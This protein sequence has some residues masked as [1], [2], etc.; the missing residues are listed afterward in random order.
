MVP[1]VKEAIA[2]QLW[3]NQ[4]AK[5]NR[6]E[7]AS[8]LEKNERYLWGSTSGALELDPDLISLKMPFD[9]ALFI[10]KMLS[11][12]RA[13]GTIAARAQRLLDRY[14]W[15]GPKSGT[16]AQWTAWWSENKPYAFATDSSKYGWYLD[17]L[18]KKRGVPTADLR[19]PKRADARSSAPGR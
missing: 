3:T 13:G 1:S 19:G 10:D 11:D 15:I 9:D 17:P 7:L 6:V 4:L 14:V 12:L 8:W 5:L 2:P 18:A 16:L